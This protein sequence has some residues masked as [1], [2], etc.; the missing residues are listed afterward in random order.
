MKTGDIILVKCKGRKR[1]LAYCIGYG[2]N[3]FDHS[4][5][6][7]SEFISWRYFD[8]NGVL[9]TRKYYGYNHGE[10]YTFSVINGYKLMLKLVKR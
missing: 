7:P 1:R 4:T 10:P 3:A 5:G 8:N 9:T 6:K 2:K